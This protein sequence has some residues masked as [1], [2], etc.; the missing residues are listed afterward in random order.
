MVKMTE[1]IIDVQLANALNQLV[2]ATKLKVDKRR[3]GFWCP[4]CGRPVRPHLKSKTHPAHFE[5]VDRNVACRFSHQ[6]KQRKAVAASPQ[7]ATSL[8]SA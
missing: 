2:Y 1:C 6:P 5:H 7:P 3:I 4:E 8:R